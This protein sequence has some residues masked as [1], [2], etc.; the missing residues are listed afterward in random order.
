MADTKKNSKTKAAGKASS[1]KTAAAKK[2]KDEKQREKA[3]EKL[4]AE[5]YQENLRRKK[6]IRDNI[7]A[8]IFIVIGIFFIVSLYTNSTGAVGSVVKTVLSGLFG[9]FVSP[10]IGAFFVLFGILIFAKKTAFL[11]FRTLIS[12]VL[13]FVSASC[14]VAARDASV[15]MKL[16]DVRFRDFYTTG[17]DGGGFIGCS[18]SYLLL[19]AVGKTGLYLICIALIL[20]SLMFILNTPISSFFDNLKLK[21][22]AAKKAREERLAAEAEGRQLEIEVPKNVPIIPE[23]I[24]PEDDEPVFASSLSEIEPIGEAAEK[25]EAKAPE[26][27]LPVFRFTKEDIGIRSNAPVY[28]EFGNEMGLQN[29]PQSADYGDISDNQKNILDMLKD[30]H[31]FDEAPRQSGS[32]GL[33][34]DSL[35]QSG[36]GLPGGTDEEPAEAS[37]EASAAAEE[38][39]SSGADSSGRGDDKQA[40]ADFAPAAAAAKPTAKKKSYRFPPINLL[41][42]NSSVVGGANGDLSA[43][44]RLLED[45]LK[46][47]GVSAKVVDVVR[48]PAVTRFEVQPA[49]GVKVSSI[50]HL[51]DDLALNLR[52]K[53]LRMEAPIPG[54][55]AVGVE[56]SNEAI[57]TVYLREILESK[58][59]KT[60]KS[61]ISVGLGRSVAGEPVIVNLKDMPHLLIAGA[62][63][64]GKSVCINS[65]IISL[66][67]KADPSEVKLILI[68][69]KVVELSMYNGIPHLITPV[70]TDPAKASAALSWAVKEMNDRYDKFA[71][72]GV[73][74]LQSFN[75]SVLANGEDDRVMPQMVIIIDELADLVMAAKNQV[76]D[77]I[78]RIAQKARAAGMHLI[79]ATQRPSVDVITGVIKAN[80]PSRIAFS[81]SSQVDSRTI[82]DMQGAEKL[83]GKGDMLYYPT[84]ISKPLRVQGC[85]VSDDEVKSVIDFVKNSSSSDQE[86]RYTSEI[87]DAMNS[88]GAAAAEA[89]QSGEDELLTDAIETV[90]RA[91]QASVSMLQRRFRIGYNRAARLIDIMEERGIVG[92][93]DGARPRKVNMTIAQFEEL[94]SG[95]D[96]EVPEEI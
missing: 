18:L 40:V 11:T 83:L 59:F 96:R 71:G 25:P 31:L 7:A 23:V 75:E 5:Q 2:T 80:V 39:P 27:D 37:T 57:N 43:Q 47:F 90:V 46:S 10:I 56:I 84:G 65:I 70:V 73:R 92:P 35:I 91:E 85:Y 12:I 17:V 51:Q 53:S 30:E 79:I 16:V 49:T 4:L 26:D 55:A 69:P 48:G 58:E 9:R 28:D 6:Q 44:S 3:E 87:S 52:A 45:T 76:E 74:D 81:V 34:G 32:F 60:S 88:T 15:L 50:V 14:I 54:K 20:V 94:A 78:C 41:R 8:V 62:T 93:A 33:N 72:E 89:D 19:K 42:K 36:R 82:L 67:Y 77:S 61:K 86:S 24:A 66:L 38:K 29:Q 95:Q 22:Q 13:L 64:S 21:A 1:A 63:G 68:D